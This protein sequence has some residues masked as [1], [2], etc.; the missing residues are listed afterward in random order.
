MRS[1]CSSG[2]IYWVLL[3]SGRFPLSKTIIPDAKEH[4]LTHSPRRDPHLFG[5]LGFSDKRRPLPALFEGVDLVVRKR[6]F[7]GRSEVLRWVLGGLSG[8]LQTLGELLNRLYI[9]KII[10]GVKKI[11][12]ILAIRQFGNSQ[13]KFVS[14]K[15]CFLN[16][17]SKIRQFRQFRQFTI[18]S[19]PP[20]FV[21]ERAQSGKCARAS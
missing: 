15:A 17:H 11:T 13:L 12:F 2:S 8:P 5:G 14:G 9:G 16:C 19:E 10:E 7:R 3:V 1:G 18:S 6:G 4:F 20:G 21:S